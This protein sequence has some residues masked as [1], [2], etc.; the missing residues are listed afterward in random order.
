M[1]RLHLSIRGKLLGGSLLTI[2]V[3][4]IGFA[5]ALGQLAG[6]KRSSE[7]L[8]HNA[9]VPTVAAD[10]VRYHVK[11]LTLQNTNYSLMVAQE[12]PA[13]A[14]ADQKALAPLN[15]A[16]AADQQAIHRALPALTAG[17]TGLR[18]LGAVVV[19]AAHEYDAAMTAVHKAGEN[20]SDVAVM[21]RALGRLGRATK[22]LDTAS[23]RYVQASGRYAQ[24]AVADVSATY[25][26]G[27]LVVLIALLAAIAI[28]LGVGLRT[29]A[30]V[31]RGVADIK[32]TLT[33]LRESDTAALRHGLD[34]VAEGDLTQPAV[35][36]TAPLTARTT[37]EIGDVARLVEGIR[38]DTATSL[39]SYNASIESLAAM[40]GHVSHS[41]T[42]LAG[43]S[44][45]VAA[46]SRES[47]RAVGEIA[48][49]VES[50]AAG[51]ERQVSAVTGA[52]ELTQQ[53]GTAIAS[54]AATAESTG[55][56]ADV[57][58]GTAAEGAAA[59]AQAT[60]AMSAVREAS[61][62][63]TDAIRQLGAKS[64]EIGG[65]VD[66]ITGIAE[67][68]NLLA[69]NAAIEAARAGEQGRGFAVVA[70]EVR[71]LAEESQTAAASISG[72]IA[73]IQAETARAVGVVESGAQR[74]DQGAATVEEA[75]TAFSRINDQVEEMAARV[76][77]ISA[78]VSELSITSSRMD[79][80]IAAV[81]S[82]SEETSATTEQVAASTE[83]TSASTQEITAAAS[84][85][86]GTADELQRLVG[87]FTLTR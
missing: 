33:S 45:Q 42:T 62:Q 78:A 27:R 24:D 69:L 53:M 25:S 43:A 13:K 40:I 87:R 9:Y 58:R 38:A 32:R 67:Q 73:E 60:E 83:E 29:S 47:G 26:R 8:H 75:R 44:E 56:A 50:V 59:V 63:A 81:A 18:S 30:T 49:A 35:A 66:A 72:L 57:A 64:E 48:S 2:A 41:A 76:G 70:D 84:T 19:S 22:A 46:M 74:T 55:R 77:E 61:G 12:G 11:D 34:A 15:A 71:K 86:A 31:R 54:S 5:V 37:D 1:S 39:S 28:G 65:I 10:A 21:N 6:V 36:E 20:P 4:A 7:A 82:V 17:P 79:A 14:A 23:A 16:V 85:L 51:A 80:E 52:R 68:T 3:C